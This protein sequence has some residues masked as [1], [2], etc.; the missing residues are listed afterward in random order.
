MHD[1]ILPPKKVNTI[2]L[3][4]KNAIVSTY[5]HARGR[6]GYF[7]LAHMCGFDMCS[8]SEFFS[9][10]TRIRWSHRFS[11]RAWQPC[12]QSCRRRRRIGSRRR[13]PCRTRAVWKKIFVGIAKL[14]FFFFGKMSPRIPQCPASPWSPEGPLSA[15]KKKILFIRNRLH[16]FGGGEMFVSWPASPLGPSVGVFQ[17]RRLGGGVEDLAAVEPTPRRPLQSHGRPGRV[18]PGAGHH[19]GDLN[20]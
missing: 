14:I 5:V 16:F 8:N 2:Y 6:E 20:I 19:H 1:Q 15:W 13:S 11:R 12:R 17:D 3:N 4:K 18:L 10:H 9:S 7:P